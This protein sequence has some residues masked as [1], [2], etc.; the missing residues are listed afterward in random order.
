MLARSKRWPEANAGLNWFGSTPY[1][2][3]EIYLKFA[4]ALAKISHGGALLP[5]NSAGGVKPPL[6]MPQTP[7]LQT[8]RLRLAPISVC[9]R[10]FKAD[11]GQI[12]RAP[13]DRLSANG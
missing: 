3:P 1:K 2:L 5:C 4:F 9:G 6:F 8:S 7:S 11:K 12:V 10:I 13:H